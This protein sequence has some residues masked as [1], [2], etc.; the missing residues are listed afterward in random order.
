MSPKTIAIPLSIASGNSRIRGAGKKSQ[1]LRENEAQKKA[2]FSDTDGFLV[3]EDMPDANITMIQ[4]IQ[5][6]PQSSNG[7]SVRI[8]SKIDA[9]I[10]M[11]VLFS[12]EINDLKSIYRTE[13][14]D[15]KKIKA[16]ENL[17][18]CAA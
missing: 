16:G 17:L 7:A 3:L 4:E 9:L 14:A 15:L 2:G 11:T 13:V 1:K 12:T 5:L 8:E 10:A 6:V 18:Y